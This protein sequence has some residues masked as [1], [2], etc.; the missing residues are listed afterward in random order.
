MNH[1]QSPAQ[2]KRTLSIVFFVMLMD[3]VGLSIIF[4]VAPFIVQRYSD[5]AVTVTLLSGIYAAAQFFAAPAMGNISD[6]VGRRPVL[7][8]SVFGSAIGYFIFGIGGA[9]WILFLSRVIDGVTGGNL[10]T[11]SAYIADVSP[12]ADRAKNFGLIGVA[13]GLGFILGPALGGLVSQISIDAPAFLAGILS[14]ISVGVMYFALPESLPKEKRDKTPLSLKDFNPLMSIGDMLKKPNLGLLLL[15]VCVFNFA[16]SGTS[17]VVGVYS[18]QRL[19]ATP[20]QIGMLFVV[21]GIIT[22]IVQA[23]IVDPTVKRYGEK[24][25]AIVSLLCLG[26]GY[27][28]I[29]IATEFWML[30][31]TAI[32]RNGIGG[33]FWGT[34][35]ALTASK[36]LPREQGK[37]AGV[38]T[39]IQSLM[40]AISPLAAGVAYDNIAPG[41]PFLLGAGVFLIGMLLTFVIKTDPVSEKPAAHWS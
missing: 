35:G 26:L 36:V 4:P 5:S 40:S 39:A 18:A 19:N 6:R 11:A 15:I 17:S 14:L 21:G 3:I 7:L 28:F 34:L 30:Y 10:S 22:A 24:N 20:A 2:V 25:M 29:A 31:P 9:L 12:P 1:P 32:L 33:F 16:F 27:G 8:I 37:L 38:N 23:K 41:A 13:F